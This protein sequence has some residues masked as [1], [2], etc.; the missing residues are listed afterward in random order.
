MY[1]TKYQIYLVCSS[2]IDDVPICVEFRHQSWFNDQFK[3]QTLS[4]LTEHHIIHSVVDEPQVREGS[5]PLVNRIT[6]ETALYAI[7]EEIDKAGP[8]R[9]DRPRVA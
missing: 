4:F 9:H 2:T 5:I 7:M 6:T 1:G 8:K 3:E